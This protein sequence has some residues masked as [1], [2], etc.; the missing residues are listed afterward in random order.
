[1]SRY[2]SDPRVVLH[3]DGTATLPDVPGG[4]DDDWLVEHGRRGGF[5][6]RN[7]ERGGQGHLTDEG[8]RHRRRHKVFATR[9]EAIAY[10]L[11]EPRAS[12]Y[13][14]DPRVRPHPDGSWMVFSSDSRT[15]HVVR[16]CG[17]VWNAFDADGYPLPA[18]SGKA[19]KDE[20]IRALIGNPR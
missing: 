3:D 20:A 4:T 15:E 8:D 17:D 12:A 16:R 9:D 7:D 19:T 10:V 18:A 5:V 14:A 1:M 11:G 2:R 13:D 6:V